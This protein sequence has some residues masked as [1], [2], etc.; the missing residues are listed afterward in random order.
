MRALSSEPREVRRYDGRLLEMLETSLRSSTAYGLY[1]FSSTA[2]SRLVK[3]AAIAIGCFQ[4]L[5]FPG[6]LTVEQV[7]T[8]TLIHLSLNHLSLPHLTRALSPF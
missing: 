8:L 4:V 6:T 3:V 2:L 1:L 5:M 7:T